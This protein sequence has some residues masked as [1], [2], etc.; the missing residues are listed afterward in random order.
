[1]SVLRKS[2]EDIAHMVINIPYPKPLPKELLEY[3][4]YLLDAGH[5]IM[6]I[7][8]SH[9]EEAEKSGS[10]DSYEIAVPVKYVLSHKYQFLET[11]IDKY[12]LI[13]G[14]YDPELG[15]IVDE[16]NYEF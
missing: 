3:H 15:L 1:M 16:N 10:L 5:S 6:C 13:K 9:V 2:L 12:I 8:N 7:L 14:D 4:Y 11:P